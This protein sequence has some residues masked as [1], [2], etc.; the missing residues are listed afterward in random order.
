MKKKLFVL[1]VLLTLLFSL[2]GCKR[3]GDESLANYNFKQGYGEVKISLLPNTPPEKIYPG[4][5]FKIIAQIENLGA[6]D[7]T[8]L[9]VGVNGLD[10][11]YFILENSVQN[12]PLLEGRSLLAPSGGKNYL[13]LSGKA[14][15]LKSNVLEYRGKY[16]IVLK[17]KSTL[18]FADT[19]CLNPNFYEVYDAGCKVESKKTYSG[20]GGPLAITELEEIIIPG[21]TPSVEFRFTLENR[22][23]GKTGKITLTTPGKMSGKELTC[24]FK[25]TEE[26]QKTML[27]CKGALE[28]GNSYTTTLTAG[29][30]YDYSYQEEHELVMM[31]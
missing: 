8:E 27:V 12:I 7:T 20:Q 28:K 2:S 31:R 6:Y 24:N 29:L 1:F 18:D 21:D 17:Y 22:G 30:S 25:T 15:K 4:S 14:Q 10:K 3:S 11:N 9:K 19:V 13:E 26:E 5:D 23:Q 16:F